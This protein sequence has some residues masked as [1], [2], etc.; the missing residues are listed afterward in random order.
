MT[1]QVPPAAQHESSLEQW[2]ERIDQSVR[3]GDTE[4][5]AAMISAL[6]PARLAD[7]LEALPGARR[8]RLW[9]SIADPVGRGEILIH[10]RSEVRKQLIERT[11]PDRL[12]QS[13]AGLELDELADLYPQLPSSVAQ[14]LFAS[15]A[16]Q[17]RER[18]QHVLGYPA[19][20]AGGL[21]D[22]DALTVREDTS[23]RVALRYLR[24]LRHRMGRLPEHTT[25]LMVV[26][27]DNGYRG[28]LSLA[29]LASHDERT[30]VGTVMDREVPAI[31]ADA[32]ASRVAR[33]FE[34]QDL[35]SAPVV[36]S[37]GRLVG[38]ITVDDVVDVI[39]RDSERTFMQPA[40]LDQS[41]DMFAPLALTARRRG[42]WLAANLGNAAVAS[43]VISQ[44]DATIQQRV[45]LAVL[46][47]IVASMGGVAGIQTLTLVTRA[48][49][50][51]QISRANGLRLLVHETAVNLC[52]GLIIAGIL[53][54]V[55][56]LWFGDERLGMV[57]GLALVVNFCNAAMSGTLIPLF[58]DR[59]GIDPA[60]AGGVVLTAAT[61][62]IG[63]F[64]FLA[65]GTWL[66]L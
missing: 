50:L 16:P 43:W 32:S 20:S 61:D 51:D 39:R 58:L 59:L 62:I 1:W 26:D 27:R 15:M 60:L 46:M 63:F 34:E 9:Q 45:A 42:I 53:G 17:R 2:T 54:T 38:R 3:R 31:P 36:D 55:A 56:L 48:L 47:P 4:A 30:R 41:E 18:L 28:I 25:E 65:L 8:E 49:A 64:S 13:L 21:M 12:L 24:R 52:N 57:F 35:V 29:D 33:I 19:E 37:F 40:G 7:I 10:A 22:A 23:L 66:L 11:D 5:T 44:F 6:H 14:A